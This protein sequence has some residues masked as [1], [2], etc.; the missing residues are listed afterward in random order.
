LL[1]QDSLAPDTLISQDR[2]LMARS[3]GTL[4]L[5]S[6][7]LETLILLIHADP[8]RNYIGVEISVVSGV[9]LGVICFLGYRRLPRWFFHVALAYGSALIALAA[10]FE[11]TAA[12]GVVTLYLVW[13]VLLANLFF[14]TR[15]ALLHVL[16]ATVALATVLYL[17]DVDYWQN[18]AIG[19]LF[20]L[21]TAG[22]VVGRLRKRVEEVAARLEQEA[23]TD[24]VT[25]LANRRGFNQR[26][27]LEIARAEREEG[28]V[29]VIVSDLDL[30]KRVNDELG[31]DAGDV[32]L[33]R[34]AIAIRD[35]VRKIDALGRLGGEEFGIVLPGADA[36]EAMEVALRVQRGVKS[37]FV[38]HAVKLTVSSGVA[39]RIGGGSREGLLRSADHAMYEAKR[40]G[41]DRALAATNGHAERSEPASGYRL[42]ASSTN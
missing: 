30:F 23:K 18:F 21:G 7:I 27:D 12:A 34:A 15:A 10:T 32:A 16:F 39:T 36:E 37:A 3:F 4:A 24:P 26:C 28:P 11:A 14:R 29:S 5:V 33:R 20:V 6:T 38:G 19:G 1:W 40:L 13:V 17:R 35:S 22:L 9:V 8:K 31:H 41:R 25:G 2:G 42:P